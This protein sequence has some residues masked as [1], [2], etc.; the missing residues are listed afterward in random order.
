MQIGKTAVKGAKN[1]V[2]KYKSFNF[3]FG[4][5]YEQ[6]DFAWHTA[7]DTHIYLRGL[8]VICMEINFGKLVKDSEL[9]LSFNAFSRNHIL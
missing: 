1:R 5:A 2:G 8:N 3:M 4:V 9:I 6:I 7:I